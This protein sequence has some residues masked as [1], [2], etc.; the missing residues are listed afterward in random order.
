MTGQTRVHVGSLAEA[1]QYHAILYAAAE[2]ETDSIVKSNST[3]CFAGIL[4]EQPEMLT[5]RTYCC[6]C[7][8]CRDAKSEH[9][10]FSRCPKINTVGKWVQQIIQ[11]VRGISRQ[12]KD[13]RISTQAFANEM[14][15]DHLYAA[16]ASIPKMGGRDYWLL[17]MKLKAKKAKQAIRVFEGVTIRKDQYYIDAQWYLCTSE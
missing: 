16:F 10:E 5:T 1:G 2:A 13:K 9:L 8:C 3:Y 17:L 7:Q 15:A 11:E 14:K 12:Q 4:A 6:S